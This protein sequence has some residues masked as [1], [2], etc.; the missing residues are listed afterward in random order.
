MSAG[1]ATQ[2][3]PEYQLEAPEEPLELLPKNGQPRK[4]G[5]GAYLSLLGFATAVDLGKMFWYNGRPVAAAYVQ[6]WPYRKIYHAIVTS[7]IQLA[8]VREQ[9]LEWLRDELLGKDRDR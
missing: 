3:A 1:A 4:W 5:P 8:G 6:N 7:S 9:Y 2:R